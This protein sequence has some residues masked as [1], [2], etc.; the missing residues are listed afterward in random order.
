MFEQLH[1][2]YGYNHDIPDILDGLNA[3]LIR[4][5]Q[6]YG[7]T[8]S[9]PIVVSGLYDKLDRLRQLYGPDLTAEEILDGL[10][11]RKLQL[12]RLVEMQSKVMVSTDEH[13]EQLLKR[14]FSRYVYG[15]SREKA[16]QDRANVSKNEIVKNGLRA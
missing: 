13:A 10:I 14:Q 8:R 16:A 7:P 6:M 15:L 12:N 9:I 3:R 11:E 4:A 5:R 1:R 2:L